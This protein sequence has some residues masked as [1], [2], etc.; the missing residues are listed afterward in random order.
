MSDA[1]AQPLLYASPNPDAPSRLAIL[2]SVSLGLGVCAVISWM[3][4]LGGW[5]DL[6]LPVAAI[7]LPLIGAACGILGLFYDARPRVGTLGLLF[8]GLLGCLL[9]CLYLVHW[10]YP[11]SMS[12]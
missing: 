3:M 9:S 11:L 2:G 6:H 8:N 1:P 5:R 10:M 7:G 12:R 4:Y